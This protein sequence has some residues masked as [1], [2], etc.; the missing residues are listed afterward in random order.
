MALMVVFFPKNYKSRL[1]AGGQP[2]SVRYKKILVSDSSPPTLAKFWLRAWFSISQFNFTHAAWVV[3]CDGGQRNIGSC[4][5]A[6]N[7][8]SI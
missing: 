2:L 6:T 5:N 1:V 7:V 8:R 4:L 3:K